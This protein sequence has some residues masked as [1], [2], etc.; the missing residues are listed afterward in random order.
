MIMK[1]DFIVSSALIALLS[2]SASA[3]DLY[4]SATYGINDQDNLSNDGSF[5]SNFETGNIDAL[6][7]PLVIPAGSDVNWSTDLDEGDSYTFAFGTKINNFRVELEYARSDAD[8]DSHANVS[9]AGIDLTNLDAGIL[10]SGVEGDLGVSAGNLVAD[11]WGE[12]ITTA[13]YVNGYYDFDTGTAW[14]PFIG[15]GIGYGDTEVSYKPS[16]VTIIDDEDSSTMYQL[17]AGIGYDLTESANIYAQ[18]RY[19]DSGEVS[20]NSSLLPAEFDIDNESMVFDMG[21]RYTF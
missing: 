8:I 13:F 6:P 5:T 19:R 21:I 1:R 2:T 17:M 20:V 16:G 7:A 10:V 3:A 14:T 15:A 12:I 18:V 11:G 9:A 4:V